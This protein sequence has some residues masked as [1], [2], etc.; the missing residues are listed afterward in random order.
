MSQAKSNLAKQNQA[1]KPYLKPEE[2]REAKPKKQVRVDR[3]LT[4]MQI[5]ALNEYLN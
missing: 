1:A 2:K 4:K 5:Q 3:G